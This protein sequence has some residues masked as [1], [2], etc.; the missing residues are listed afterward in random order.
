MYETVGSDTIVSAGKAISNNKQVYKS[1]NAAP[2]QLERDGYSDDQ[3][4]VL[5]K[6]RL[7]ISNIGG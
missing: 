6:K 7:L 1:L 2:D 5:L 3:Y 4:E